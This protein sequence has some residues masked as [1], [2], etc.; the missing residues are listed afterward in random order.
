MT[1]VFL[2]GPWVTNAELL[3]PP[4]WVSG[5]ERGDL[6]Y[7]T[8][9]FSVGYKPEVGNGFL[10]TVEGS[11]ALYVAGLFN[12]CLPG[13]DPARVATN[14]TCTVN[15]SR[16]AQVPAPLAFELAGALMR[17][18]AL[19][20]RHAAFIRR[21][22]LGSTAAELKLYAHRTRKGLLVLELS[23]SE[24]ISVSLER[25]LADA[26]GSDDLTLTRT[27]RQLSGQ[28][29]VV[30]TGVTKEPE[31][32]SVPP[33][34]IAMVFPDDVLGPIFVHDEEPQLFIAA[35]RT[36]LESE[37]PEAAA[38]ADWEA[39]QAAG[40]AVLRSEH[41]AAWA[42]LWE[43]GFEVAGRP[44]VARAV[45]ASLYFL[46]SSLR[47]DTAHSISPGG[48]ASNGYNGHAFWDCETW[49]Y[50]PMLLWNPDLAASLLQY[51]SDRAAVA[52]QKAQ[53]HHFE[54]IMFPWE[55]AATGAEEIAGTGEAAIYELHIN[56]DIVLAAR[57]FWYATKNRT[58]LQGTY[59]SV[60][61]DSADF[62]VSR[63]VINM[64]DGTAHLNQIIP[65]D[66]FAFGN[67]SVYTNY[68]VKTSL[69]FALE[70]AQEL[71]EVSDLRW[72]DVAGRLVLPFDPV[73]NIHPEYAGYKGQ[74][75]KQADVV[76]LGFPLMMEMP[77]DVRRADLEYYSARTDPNGPAMTW[78]MYAVGYLELG[79]QAL[80]SSNFDRSFLN[81]QPPFNV[82]TEGPH[83]GTTNFVTGAG[84]F[85]QAV[86]FGLFGLRIYAGRLS[87]KPTLLTGMTF[88]RLRGLHYR[89][90]VLDIDFSSQGAV[91]TTRPNSPML[92]LFDQTTQRTLIP[93]LSVHVA[94]NSPFDL[95]AYEDP[96][97]ILS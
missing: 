52:K 6:L 10:A 96:M 39:A 62:W 11:D 3:V 23:A 80:A 5:Y 86:T 64:T 53:Q 26:M 1:L 18:A 70:A 29:V 63:A 30:M 14:A 51:R 97:P 12:G 85:L 92:V 36:S 50:P 65:P 94:P 40:G 82:W 4:D 47:S 9:L 58:W 56:A 90:A 7:T 35:L 8:D 91:V 17:T 16:R 46:F 27:R 59:S 81:V 20:L 44:D 25:G 32:L 71:G 37:D 31:L 2:L 77:T 24:T 33:T 68:A 78:A 95:R 54:G 61:K 79:E 66:E 84:G 13:S 38:I 83:G 74:Q 57:Q 67:D 34:R 15:P 87:L 69:L 43:S 75:V 89:G 49:M 28:R 22:V 45:N 19:D 76:L 73:L 41:T 55:S 48:L 72:A 93:G 21:Y 88:M 42:Q 60:I